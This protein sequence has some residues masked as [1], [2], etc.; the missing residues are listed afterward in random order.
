MKMK[1]QQPKTIQTTVGLLGRKSFDMAPGL[2]GS[3]GWGSQ[4]QSPSRVSLPKYHSSL[5]GQFG[6]DLG[7]L[8]GAGEG[9]ESIRYKPWHIPLSSTTLQED[10]VW[11][12]S[13]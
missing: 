8:W 13:A 1:T 10:F 3:W 7:F 12:S 6:E 5:T 2:Q 4:Q 9:Q 11:G